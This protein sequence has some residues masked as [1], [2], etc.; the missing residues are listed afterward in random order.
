[1]RNFILSILKFLTAIAA[2]YIFNNIN[3]IWCMLSV[4][5]GEA[6]VVYLLGIPFINFIEKHKRIGEIIND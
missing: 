1:M 5:L 4:A 6:V 3:V 2:V